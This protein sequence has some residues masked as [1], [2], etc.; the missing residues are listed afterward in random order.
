MDPP[1]LPNLL[2]N[3]L[4][5]DSN[6]EQK[7]PDKQLTTHGMDPGASSNKETGPNIDVSVPPA[8]TEPANKEG[9]CNIT[10]KSAYP[11]LRVNK[12]NPSAYPY[13]PQNSEI[14]LNKMQTL[15]EN[16][17]L[18]SPRTVMQQVIKLDAPTTTFQTTHAP[19]SSIH[20]MSPYEA[21][22]S[23]NVSPLNSPPRYES[24]TS[25]NESPV[26]SPSM[27]LSYT[28]SP[29]SSPQYTNED[30]NG[31]PVYDYEPLSRSPSP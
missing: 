25:P 17:T 28:P 3:F 2:K 20:E 31:S 4:N 6:F 29:R 27:T 24:P 18:T 12:S 1:N 5:N 8:P 26:N 21:P 13:L 10:G 7:P 16:D 9:M 22:S 30:L 11:Y 14:T 23:P 19:T 15:G